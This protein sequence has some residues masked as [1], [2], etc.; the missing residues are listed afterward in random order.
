[1][2]L[3]AVIYV[4]YK[5]WDTVVKYWN[6]GVNSIKGFIASLGASIVVIGTSIKNTFLN[7]VEAVKEAFKGMWASIESKGIKIVN[8]MIETINNLT[9]KL[10]VLGINIPKIKT[11]GSKENKEKKGFT[12]KSVQDMPNPFSM[13]RNAL[14]TDY[15]RGGATEINE[16]G[17]EMAIMPSGSKIIPADK[18]DKILDNNKGIV[19]YVTV[20]GNVIGNEEYADYLGD[21]IVKR[22]IK[23]LSNV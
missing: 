4:L 22:V 21:H 7:V 8:G 12:P 18:T 17:G 15:F 20:Q 13:P 6:I 1:M 23:D 11:I 5:N 16:R 2:A 9:G 19:V 3:V 14:G 10:G